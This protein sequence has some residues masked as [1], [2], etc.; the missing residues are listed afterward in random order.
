MNCFMCDQSV[1]SADC[2][3]CLTC[4]KIYHYHCGGIRKAKWERFSQDEKNKSVCGECRNC[5]SDIHQKIDK[6]ETKILNVLSLKFDELSKK[7]SEIESSMDL[8]NNQFEENKKRFGQIEESQK[9]NKKCM[10]TILAENCVL[11]KEVTMMKSEIAEL[12]QRSRA[13]NVEISGFPETKNEDLFVVMK[14]IAKYIQVPFA[15]SDIN[16][17]HRVDSKTAKHRP[18]VANF[19]SKRLRDVWVA[20]GKKVKNIK[21]TDINHG[22]KLSTIFVGEHISPFYKAL[23]GKAK[24]AANANPDFKYV[25][26]SGGKVRAKRNENAKGTVIQSE[27]DVIKHIGPIPTKTNK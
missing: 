16:I 22:L 6:M 3:K 2:V 24:A 25:W 9:R 23:L 1:Q 17:I 4:K 21:S 19:Q 12:Q 27:N 15:E 18:I 11:K 20:N 14:D 10:D 13:Q 7:F 26:F 8:M 5:P